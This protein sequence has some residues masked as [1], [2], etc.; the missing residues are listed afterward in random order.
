MFVVTRNKGQ[1]ILFGDDVKITV[2][3]TRGGQVHFGITAPKHVAVLRQEIATRNAQ[4]RVR[5]DFEGS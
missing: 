1:P 4:S 3:S 2:V 5:E